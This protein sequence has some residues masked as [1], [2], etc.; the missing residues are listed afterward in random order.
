M[1]GGFAAHGVYSVAV[2][3]NCGVSPLSGSGKK[4]A[5]FV[6]EYSVALIF[7]Y[8]VCYNFI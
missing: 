3:K 1:M 5:T 7:S 6:T 4:I 2:L 8:A